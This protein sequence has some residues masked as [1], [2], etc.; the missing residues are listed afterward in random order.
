MDISVK[1]I[2]GLVIIAA[3][4]AF[5]LKNRS[6]SMMDTLMKK[7]RE[8]MEKALAELAEQE[9]AQAAE[10]EPAKA[11]ETQPKTGNAEKQ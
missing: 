3:S 6:Q 1:V 11:A 9:A 2:V 8:D 10:A 5:I 4:F 7:R